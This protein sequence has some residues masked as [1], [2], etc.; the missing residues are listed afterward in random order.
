[1]DFQKC[2][3]IHMNIHDFW[4]TVFNYPYK[5]GYPHW[6]PSRGIH[7][8]TFYNW[9]PWKHIHV[10]MDI[11]LQLS[12]LSWISICISMDFYGYL[13]MDLLWIL[14]PG[15]NQDMSIIMVF[16]KILR[17]ITISMKS[18][19]RDL[20]FDMVIDRFIFK[21]NRITL[22]PGFNFIPKTGVGLPRG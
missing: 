20:F 1:M 22:S 17:W 15:I 13:C 10:F 7:A 9:Y 5:S 12:I 18:S 21:N 3:V 11:S 14:A 2:M 8:R 19:R 4:M 16:L 6:Y